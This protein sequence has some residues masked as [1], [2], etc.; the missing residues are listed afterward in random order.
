MRRNAKI[1][2]S[3][4]LVAVLIAVTALSFSS[5]SVGRREYDT[6]VKTVTVEVTHKSGEKVEHVIETAATNLGTALSE[7]GFV[8][9]EDGQYGFYI[10][11]VDGEV[12]DY[13]VD[14]SFWSITKDGEELFTG[15]SE[16]YISDGE[17]YELTYTVYG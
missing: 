2:L 11:A 9:G 3:R 1:I 7:S 10:N 8:E 14:S 15:A 6:R 5:C 16:T 13:N 17:H 12:A 4:S